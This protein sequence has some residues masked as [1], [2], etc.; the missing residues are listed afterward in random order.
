[1]VTKTSE[2]KSEPLNQTASDSVGK[3]S[4]A[5]QSD[6]STAN[7]NKLP[8]GSPQPFNNAKE[9]KLLGFSRKKRKRNNDNVVLSGRALATRTL[10]L[11]KIDGQ[12]RDGA[13]QSSSVLS[14]LSEFFNN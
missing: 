2:L 1:M 14:L 5:A 10:N 6:S 13:N 8:L 12:Q 3:K 4:F 11:N 7:S 9:E